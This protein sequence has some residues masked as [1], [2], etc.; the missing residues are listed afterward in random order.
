MKCLQKSSEIVF[1]KK[2]VYKY[3]SHWCQFL[4]EKL[5]LIFKNV[6]VPLPVSL[7]TTVLIIE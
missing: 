3:N 6:E 5:F 7:K 2:M 4:Y 1:K